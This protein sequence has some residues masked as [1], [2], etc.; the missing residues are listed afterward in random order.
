MSD[1]MLFTVIFAL[2]QMELDTKKERV[3]YSLATA[4]HMVATWG[5]LLNFAASQI[6]T[7]GESHGRWRAR[8]SRRPQP[9]HELHH[10]L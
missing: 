8:H 9:R 7:P 5:R 10:S 4:E 3:Q 1:A 2:T 6:A